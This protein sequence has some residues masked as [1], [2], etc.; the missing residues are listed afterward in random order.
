M[1]HRRAE[2]R[3]LGVG[4]ISQIADD[5]AS[6]ARE[7]VE[8]VGERLA[9]ALAGVGRV[10]HLVA[11]MVERLVEALL[12]H[13]ERPFARPRQEV[14]DES[15]E[16]KIVAVAVGRPQAEGAARVL[17]RH[18]PVDRLFQTPVEI[19]VDRE[20][21]ERR[22]LIGVEQRHGAADRLFGAAI[23]VT[24]ERLQDRR[25]VERAERRSRDRDRSG[26]RDEVGD[27]IVGDRLAGAGR[28]RMD[29][30]AIDVGS[31]R[32]DAERKSLGRGQAR[33]GDLE[34]EGRGSDAGGGDRHRH[35]GALM[36]VELHRA[37]QGV[38]VGRQRPV[39]IEV[40]PVI[41]RFALDIVDVDV[42][43]RAVAEVEEARQ[44]R[45]DD[46]GIAH[47][48]R[49]LR[50]A[51]LGFRPGDRHH[52]D[53]TV[54][55]GNVERDARRAV[56]ADLD[57]A[58]KQRQRR[59]GRQIAFQIAAAVAADLQRAG[60]AVHAVDQ[61]AIEIADFDR[62]LALA[63]EIAARLRRL[64]PRQIEDADVDRGDRRPRPLRRRR[65][66]RS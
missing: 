53:R 45:G 22:Q 51:D 15:V 25:G 54:E 64:V 23:G 40:E 27:Q 42:H 56:G 9:R 50:R 16:P 36:R 35:R 18:L 31:A 48:H 11:Q 39:N 1:R 10:D 20:M 46:D 17:P 21:F 7:H 8:R 6:V 13:G 47:D 34:V 38:G 29:R 26:A 59:L 58:G 66:R 12:R 49:R 3:Q 14:G 65:G 32:R 37:G 63:E 43:L 61:H 30:A 24:V 2:R 4:E 57:D 55:G 5:R 33:A 62:K 60:D 28:Q 19:G 41:A 44:R 52:L